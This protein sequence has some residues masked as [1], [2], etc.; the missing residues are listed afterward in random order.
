MSIPKTSIRKP[1]T[2]RSINMWARRWQLPLALTIAAAALLSACGGDSEAAP[3]EASGGGLAEA[4]GIPGGGGGNQEFADQE[5]QIEE[6]IAA[7]MA[8]KGF[9]Y[10]AVKIDAADLPDFGDAEGRLERARTSGFG[11]ALAYD[12]P[13]YNDAFGFGGASEDA[14][15]EIVE[16]MSESE[17]TAYYEALDGTPDE[18][19]AI[20]TEVDPETGDEISLGSAGCRGEAYEAGYGD[21]AAYEAMAP[22]EEE[23]NARVDADPR[24]QEVLATWQACM[25]ERGLDYE[26]PEAVYAY[27][28]GEFK[29]RVT[30]VLGF[31]PYGGLFDQLN[32]E[33][34]AFMETASPAELEARLA[35]LEETALADI[36]R[37]ALRGLQEEER[38]LAVAEAE[39]TP[40]FYTKGLPIYTEIEARFVEENADRIAEAAAQVDG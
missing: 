28:D 22:L 23:I 18:L 6:A 34:P 13:D 35:E 14:N 2:T 9:E 21:T 19:A 40:P 4:F 10:I 29:E 30:A 25:S 37:T 39:C 5:T 20:E 38:A 15:A 31:D 24:Y 27:T 11:I 12:N 33:D 36:D 32:S 17:R 16:A 7:C 8:G 26:E 3:A 1:T